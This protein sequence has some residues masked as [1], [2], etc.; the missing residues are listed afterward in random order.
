ML[1]ERRLRDLDHLQFVRGQPCLACGRSPSDAHHLKF[2]QQRALGRKVSDEFTV[3]LCRTH[4]RE[5][6]QRGDERI[7]WQ[8]R[9]IDPLNTAHRLW[10]YTR[11]K[12]S[13]APTS[14]IIE[15]SLMRVVVDPLRVVA[16]RA[17]A[18]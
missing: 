13:D 1:T 10:Q 9:N 14:A 7:W 6:H 11:S 16:D 8:H 15:S 2:A 12:G 4:H 17:G 18:R 3:P 5:L